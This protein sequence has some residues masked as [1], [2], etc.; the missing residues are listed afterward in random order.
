MREFKTKE[1]YKKNLTEE[2]KKFNFLKFDKRSKKRYALCKR[3]P[4]F[5]KFLRQCKVC[6]CFTFIK[7]RFMNE[8]CPLGKW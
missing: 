4:S 8:T 3:C 2:L 6:L 5:N 7:V 1:E